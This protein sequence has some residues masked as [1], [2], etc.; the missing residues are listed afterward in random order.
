MLNKFFKK[1][2]LKH[3]VKDCAIVIKFDRHGEYKKLL[4]VEPFQ[5][6]TIESDSDVI[7]AG[8]YVYFKECNLKKRAACIECNLK[9][10]AAC[11]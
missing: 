9:K 4:F 1:T 10:R 2:F 6:N 3:F 8:K 7:L 5:D 11:I